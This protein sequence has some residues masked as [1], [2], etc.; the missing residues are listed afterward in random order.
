M[1]T[2][3]DLR[4][5]ISDEMKRVELSAGAAAVKY[6]VL[7]AIQFYQRR[8][9]PWN[10]FT[11][12]LH[13]TTTSATMVTLSAESITG[14]ILRLDTIKISLNS[15]EYELVPK[16]WAYLDSL[17]S[18]LYFGYPDYYAIRDNQVRLY[19][20]VQDASVLR[21]SGLKRLT[22]IFDAASN[23]ASNAWT[24]PERGA[25]IIRLKAKSILFRDHLRNPGMADYMDAESAK[26]YAEVANEIKNKSSSRR[27][28]PTR[29]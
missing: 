15:R 4:S 29:F 16:S 8:R 21:M 10:E 19:P 9:F 25:H 27:I 5:R 24:D 18:G 2:L 6:A 23:S 7:D 14:G 11:D 13:T 20:P 1:T 28:S 22:E 17:D 26:A 12:A 3:G